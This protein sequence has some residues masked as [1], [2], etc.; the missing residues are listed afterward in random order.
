MPAA[1][2]GFVEAKLK[3]VPAGFGIGFGVLALVTIAVAFAA[4]GIIEAR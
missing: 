3:A 2:A 4:D 1:G